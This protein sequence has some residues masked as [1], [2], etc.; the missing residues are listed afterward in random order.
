MTR[1]VGAVALPAP[2]SWTVAVQMVVADTATSV[3][4]HATLVTLARGTTG[5]TACGATWMSD[6]VV[7]S[8][9]PKS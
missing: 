4:E 8:D 2:V 7:S 3:G 9:P 6:C 1:P 5:M